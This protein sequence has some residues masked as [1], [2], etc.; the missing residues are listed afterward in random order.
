MISVVVRFR[1]EAAHLAAVLQAV[2]AQHCQERVEIVAVDNE[3]DDGSRQIA[4]HYADALLDIDDYRPGAAL[5]KAIEA[6]TGDTIAIVS[7]HAI[8]AN[9][10]WLA[11]LTMWRANPAVLGTYGAQLYPATSRFLDKRD[12][13]IFS[14]LRPRTEHKDSDFWNANS[15]FQRAFWDKARFDEDVFE[16]ED[17]YW[18][19][20]H[21]ASGELSVRFEP[22]ALVY[23]YGHDARN[24]RTFLPPSPLSDSERISQALDALDATD[25]SWPTV[26]SAALTLSSLAHL[27]ET[28]RTVPALGRT[29]T[30]HPDFDVRWR[31]AGAL[32]RMQDP[33]GAGYLAAALSD[34]SFY[35]RD[36]AAWSLGRL[37]PAAAPAVHRALAGLDLEFQPFGALALGL[38]GDAASGREAIAI[39]RHC[40]VQEQ[41][42]VRM[43][44]I[45]FLGE[46]A[47]AHESVSLA[48][49]AEQ[50][51]VASDDELA[52]AAAWCWG[53]L[54]ARQPGAVQGS[55]SR[56]VDLARNHPVETVRH[57]AIIA[58]G[59][60]AGALRDVSLTHHLWRALD[61]DGVGRVRYA[62]A[63]S[64]R[65]L[66]AQGL[67]VD[68]PL[69]HDDDPDFGVRFEQHIL[70]QQT[71][72]H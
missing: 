11:D 14:G 50:H 67:P 57:E 4:A 32:G 39:L 21:L 22:T 20:V 29:L 2:R 60:V 13:D 52:R 33:S 69:D 54:G 72:N 36:E 24:D 18:T 62:A 44:A 23:H 35:V 43:D 16:L 51:L 42:S 38:N 53:V 5:N 70:Q 64:L 58:L 63:Q 1:N 68:G 10:R 47:D 26:M 59:K 31:A 19:K 17:H 15:A 61:E 3:S 66:A 30:S 41:R 40:V 56:V 48:S 25:E 45:Y 49:V 9:D 27:P 65:L 34:P 12:L 28:V 71:G 37:G 8:P 6:C 46:I 7:A 55:V